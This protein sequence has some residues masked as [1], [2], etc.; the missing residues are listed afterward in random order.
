MSLL[1]IPAAQDIVRIVAS[2]EEETERQVVEY[3]LRGGGA[4]NY[5]LSQKLAPH[6]YAHSINLE[7]ALRACRHQRTAAGA[8][9]NSRVVELVWEA[10]AGRE[11]V[12]HDLRP[13]VIRIRRDMQVR[14]APAFY[15][16]EGGVT[17][18]FW[19][20]PRTNYSLSLSKMGLLA[21]LVREVFL[22]DDFE[23]VGFEILDLSVFPGTNVRRSR[24]IRQEDM[25]FISKEDLNSALQ[26]FANAFERVRARGIER[27][28]RPGKRPPTGPDLF[29]P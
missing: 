23:G 21:A 1:P 3:F 5:S 2:T 18:L 14:V 11:I 29:N 20:Q 19:L 27:K 26:R 15:Y 12:S 28:R 4:F 24:L 7:H 8:K 16:V 25:P 13:K 17:R 22:V 9:H 6:A 10:G